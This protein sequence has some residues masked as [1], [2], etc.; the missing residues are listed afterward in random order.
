MALPAPAHHQPSG[1]IDDFVRAARN[2]HAVDVDPVAAARASVELGANAHPANE[3][4]A[5]RQVGELDLW[6][7]L[8][9]LGDLDHARQVLNHVASSW[10]ALPARQGR[11]AGQGRASTSVATRPRA[12]R[13]R[14]GP[15]CSTDG[16][17]G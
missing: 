7:R 9:P 1:W 12:A 3:T 4:L 2:V 11:A 8:D 5:V 13:A 17:R 6:R 16:F 10:N 15:L 14:G